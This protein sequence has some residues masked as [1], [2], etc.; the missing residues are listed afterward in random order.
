KEIDGKGLGAARGFIDLHT[1]SDSAMTLKSTRANLNY[2]L[3]GVTTVVTG[4]CGSGPVDVADFFKKMEAGGIGS[5]VL[6]LVPHNS[7]RRQVMG[8]VN[9]APT[10]EELQK[11][12]A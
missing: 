1:H 11:M 4:N 5:N 7:V 8:N 2:L 9:R 12:H 3:Q 10:A 6:H